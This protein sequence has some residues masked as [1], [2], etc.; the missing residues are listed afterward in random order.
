MTHATYVYIAAAYLA[1]VLLSLTGILQRVRQKSIPFISKT[2]VAKVSEMSKFF[3]F[4]PS[5][6][7]FCAYLF[8]CVIQS[9]SE[10]LFKINLKFLKTHYNY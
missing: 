9:I 2:F 1:I 10:C 8:V 6:L 3:N 5:I 4:R 7:I